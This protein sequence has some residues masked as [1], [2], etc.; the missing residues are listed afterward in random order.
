M[1]HQ[2]IRTAPKIVSEYLPRDVM[3][4][5]EKG[6]AIGPRLIATNDPTGKV[7]EDI[8]RTEWHQDRSSMIWGKIKDWFFFLL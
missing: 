1:S 6:V 8:F 3:S 4:V 7:N 5:E 2:L